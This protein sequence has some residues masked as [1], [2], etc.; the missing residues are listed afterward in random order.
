MEAKLKEEIERRKLWE[1]DHFI[2]AT[3]KQVWSAGYHRGCIE[4]AERTLNWH[5]MR[6]C[7]I[8]E[9]QS[10]NRTRAEE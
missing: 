3:K 1:R 7:M 6:L 10:P 4:S 2:T 5:K 8:K 9:K